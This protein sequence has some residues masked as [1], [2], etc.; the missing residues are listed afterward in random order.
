M[1]RKSEGDKEIKRKRRS[2]EGG[3]ELGM[4]RGG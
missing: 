2:V 4:K 3:I 1:V